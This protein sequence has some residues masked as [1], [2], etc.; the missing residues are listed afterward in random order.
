MFADDA[1]LAPDH[2]RVKVRIDPDN[3]LLI[4]LIRRLDDPAM[5]VDP[6]QEGPEDRRPNVRNQLGK[7]GI[8]ALAYLG[9]ALARHASGD[10]DARQNL[11]PRL[12]DLSGFGQVG[13]CDHAALNKGKVGKAR[14]RAMVQPVFE[15]FI[16]HSPNSIQALQTVSAGG[17][18]ARC[19]S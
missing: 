14:L 13:I 6:G 16:G 10:G 1:E 5:R 15:P 9:P 19:G 11:V 7:T 18:R 12:M 2:R 4:S 8:V 17:K 3:F